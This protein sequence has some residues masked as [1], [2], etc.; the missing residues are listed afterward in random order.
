M[1]SKK[2][3]L[4]TWM[5]LK[6]TPAVLFLVYY[7]MCTR[8][9]FRAAYVYLQTAVFAAAGALVAYQIAYAKRRDIFDEFARENLKTVDSICLKA[10]YVLM[11]GAAVVCIFTDFSGEAAGYGILIS[12]L[13]LTVLRAILFA[14]IDKKGM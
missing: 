1:N 12:I 7:W 11:I 2:I 5:F 14:V 8:E 9:D 6:I 3:N 4:R 10:A 13:L